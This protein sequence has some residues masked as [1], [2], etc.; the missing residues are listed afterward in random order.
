M[1][2]GSILWLCDGCRSCG[3]SVGCGVNYPERGECFHTLEKAHALHPDHTPSKT[4][5]YFALKVGGPVK[6][7]QLYFVELASPINDQ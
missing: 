5:E 3:V 6:E 7:P 4:P 2:K 1:N